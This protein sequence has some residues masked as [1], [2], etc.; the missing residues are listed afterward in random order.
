MPLQ[1]GVVFPVHSGLPEESPPRYACT[2]SCCCCCCCCCSV[3]RLWQFAGQRTLICRLGQH[4]QEVAGV[5]QLA[6]PRWTLLTAS[7]QRSLCRSCAVAGAS[8]LNPELCMQVRGGRGRRVWQHA[9]VYAPAAL[10]R[11]GPRVCARLTSCQPADQ[12]ADQPGA[13]LLPSHATGMASLSMLCLEA[14]SLCLSLIIMV[15]IFVT[16]NKLS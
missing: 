7:S 16:G 9:A 1:E 13:A 6:K 15:L 8:W 4:G 3:Q 2:R 12:Q 10:R 11:T 5:L 14:G